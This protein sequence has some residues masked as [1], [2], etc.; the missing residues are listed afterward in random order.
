MEHNVKKGFVSTNAD[1][2]WRNLLGH[3]S[4][5]RSEASPLNS[6]SRRPRSL[7]EPD[8]SFHANDDS[9]EV[10]SFM[11][12]GPAVPTQFCPVVGD[13]SIRR[14]SHGR[15]AGGSDFRRSPADKTSDI[16]L[17][18]KLNLPEGAQ[19]SRF[20]CEAVAAP[21]SSLSTP[22]TPRKQ[23]GNDCPAAGDRSNSLHRAHSEP[24]RSE[25]TIQRRVVHRKAVPQFELDDE[26]D[27]NSD[28][29][30]SSVRRRTGMKQKTHNSPRPGMDCVAVLADIQL[31]HDIFSLVARY[32]DDSPMDG[33]FDSSFLAQMVTSEEKGKRDEEVAHWRKEMQRKSDI[34]GQMVVEQTDELPPLPT[35]I[36]SV[37]TQAANLTAKEQILHLIKRAMDSNDFSKLLLLKDDN[38]QF[39][40]DTVWEMLFN[41]ASNKPSNPHRVKRS[42]L[43]R[44]ALKLV[45][46]YDRI[47]TALFLNNVQCHSREAPFAG[48]F[49]DVYCGQFEN[50]KVA[51]KCLRTFK[52]LSDAA[53]IRLKRA[54]YRESLLWQDLAHPH[55]LPFLGVSEG[56]FQY[57]LCM[58]LPWMENGNILNHMDNL[59]KNGKLMD[60]NHGAVINQWCYETAL[61]LAYLHEEG[62]VHGDLRGANI[63]VDDRGRIRLADFGMSVI[64]ESTG[65]SS[66]RGGAQRWLSP[67][68]IDPEQ[69]NMTSSCP[70]YA[71]DVY[72]FAL[73]AIELFTG[74]PPFDTLKEHQIL[75][76]VLKENRPPRPSTSVGIMMSDCLWKVVT[77]CWVH[78]PADRPP[79]AH[80]V[81]V[82]KGTTRQ[83][84]S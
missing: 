58:V 21:L 76:H 30:S 9:D 19:V 17:W 79:A 46:R 56:V 50:Q 7:S 11:R 60:R 54:F 59:K 82:L 80:V 42:Q 55:I 32:F 29:S 18:R 48:G 38:A 70:A 28:A 68:L 67:E 5:T 78:H 62:I 3:L 14:Y 69:F 44:L 10:P 61:G 47:P 4:D 16:W 22:S 45:L 57:S 33:L 63:L 64:A 15:G 39:A 13:R 65:N 81:Q 49:A 71:S 6:D 40:V 73:T 37:L 31:I 35:P 20:T 83:H 51:L 52:M 66:V 72:S 53:K 36:P 23:I 26:S 2:T 1:P 25:C 8:C 27:V 34:Y 75:L 43:R 12:P 77:S 74:N 41:F 84:L 24:R